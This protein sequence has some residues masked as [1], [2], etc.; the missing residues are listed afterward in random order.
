M[1]VIE[2]DL[3]TAQFL[4]GELT[5]DLQPYRTSTVTLQH[6]VT[7]SRNAVPGW[8]QDVQLQQLGIGDVP[9]RDLYGLLA[10]GYIGQYRLW[11]ESNAILNAQ[12]WVSMSR[13]E[14]RR[15]WAG[16]DAV[17][18]S[19]P[20]GYLY[21]SLTE[22]TNDAARFR[23]D[24]ALSRSAVLYS[25]SAI[26]RRTAFLQDW[27]ALGSLLFERGR[28]LRTYGDLTGSRVALDS[29]AR[30][31]EECGDYRGPERPWVFAQTRQEL[32]E[33]ALD[34]A[35]LDRVPSR[36]ESLLRQARVDVDSA[37]RVLRPTEMPAAALAS[38]RSL[39][40]ELLAEL[41]IAERRPAVLEVAEDRL[42][43][44]S[45]EFPPTALPREAAWVCVRQAVL[46][47]AKFASS[48]DAREL[49][50][51]DAALD[52]ALVLMEAHSDSLVLHRVL[53]ERAAVARARGSSR[54]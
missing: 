21:N 16:P 23:A 35:R 49:E 53:R 25:D 13:V 7:L 37:L 5:W 9:Q 40:A 48:G 18:A 31:L 29:A 50:A 3:G 47:R 36:R 1:R 19:H 2:K 24:T 41:S 32:A 51:A 52:R 42:R 12:Y 54:P 11:G 10:A 45:R 22:V 17:G 30:Y 39:D 33:L 27:P 15:T 38:L 8:Q 26:A 6:A 34:R 44:A 43:E 46:A 20:W 28:A 14:F 4:L